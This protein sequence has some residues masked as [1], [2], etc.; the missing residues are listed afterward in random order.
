MQP[1]RKCPGYERVIAPKILRTGRP[2]SCP[3]C[4]IALDPDPPLGGFA[5]SLGCFVISIATSIGLLS[6]GLH[7]ALALPI[8][9]AAGILV[10]SFSVRTFRRLWPRPMDLPL[11][12]LRT[13]PDNLEPLATLLERI[14]ATDRWS[15]DLQRELSVAEKRRTR[16]DGLEEAAI[17]AARDYRELLSGTPR[18]KVSKTNRD[19]GREELRAELLSIAKDLRL[20]LGTPIR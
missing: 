8:G 11:N 5:S 18:K 14:V 10:I 1:I 17:Q 19:L 20:I 2:F 7:W 16:D 9:F 15:S 6:I 3:N 12:I 13:Y 4:K